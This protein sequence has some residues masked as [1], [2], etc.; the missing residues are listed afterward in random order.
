MSFYYLQMTYQV[1]VIV[2]Y[3]TQ[4][5]LIFIDN[6]NSYKDICD[7]IYFLFNL[8]S[9]KSRFV[10]QRQDFIKSGLFINIDERSFINDL[11]QHAT[12]N[13]LKILSYDF[14]LYQ[15]VLKIR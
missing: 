2:E 9:S 15:Q 8:D 13:I 14:V 6:D 10:I 5:Q 12:K 7:Q 1:L 4:K 11:K 3:V